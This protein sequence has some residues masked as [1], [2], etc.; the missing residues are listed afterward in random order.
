MTKQ[1]RPANH[2]NRNPGTFCSVSPSF[3]N[4]A[5]LPVVLARTQARDE[6]PRE[7]ARPSKGTPCEPSFLDSRQ[8]ALFAGRNSSQAEAA[9]LAL[10]TA[11]SY[12]T[13]TARE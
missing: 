7:D 3:C 5:C 6:K 1:E 8:L 4:A 13:P 11:H 9:P 2:A 12:R 10:T